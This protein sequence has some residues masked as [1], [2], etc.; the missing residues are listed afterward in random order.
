MRRFGVQ[1]VDGL[2]TGE[3][4]HQLA[5]LSAIVCGS[6]RFAPAAPDYGL[7]LPGFVFVEALCWFAQAARSGAWTYYEATPR[8]RQEAM[9]RALRGHGPVG[10]ADWYERGMTEWEDEDRMRAVDCWMEA[11]TAAAERWL[12]EFVRQHREVMIELTA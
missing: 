8:P 4:Y 2:L 3:D 12:R 9:A 7:P 10:Y 11:N 5:E 6:D 1:Y